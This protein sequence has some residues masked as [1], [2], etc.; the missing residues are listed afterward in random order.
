VRSAGGI[1]ISVSADATDGVSI[2]GIATRA[3]AAISRSGT[4][5]RR[6]AIAAIA[7]EPG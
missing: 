1:A 6:P 5:F 4:G 7:A 2:C 3:R